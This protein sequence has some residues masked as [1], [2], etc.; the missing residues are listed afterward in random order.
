MSKKLGVK[1]NF[2]VVID[3]KS[4]TDFGAVIVSRDFVYQGESAQA[5][6]EDDM[7]KRCMEIIEQV[8]RHCD[9]VASAFMK[10]DQEDNCEYCNSKWTESSA[11][12]NGGCCDQDE[13][14]EVRRID[15]HQK[16]IS[17]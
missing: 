12:Y 2:C 3:P 10:Y 4:M 1:D 15:A 14:A 9:H 13:E 8:R 6:W 16:A 7:T 11:T 17:G 5:H